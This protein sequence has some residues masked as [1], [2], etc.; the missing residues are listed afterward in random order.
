MSLGPSTGILNVLH[1]TDFIYPKVALTQF[2]V[3]TLFILS[4]PELSK[5]PTNPGFLDRDLGH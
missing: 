2:N 1:R 3:S 4:P 5:R